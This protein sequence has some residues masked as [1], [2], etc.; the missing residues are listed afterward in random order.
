MASTRAR[1]A[2]VRWVRAVLQLRDGVD[3]AQ[4]ARV[5][6]QEGPVLDDPLEPFLDGELVLLCTTTA[7]IVRAAPLRHIRSTKLR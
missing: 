7:R 5:T 6:R 1:A 2:E 4:Q 3:E